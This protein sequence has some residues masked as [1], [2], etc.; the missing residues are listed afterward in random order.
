MRRIRPDLFIGRFT[1]QLPTFDSTE[2]A[3][4]Y[5]LEDMYFPA[6]VNY[7]VSMAEMRNDQSAVDGRASAFLGLFSLQMGGG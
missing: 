7:M 5:P 4:T 2:T 1:T 6:S 3:K